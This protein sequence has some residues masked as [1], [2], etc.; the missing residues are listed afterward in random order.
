MNTIKFGDCVAGMWRLEPESVDLAF[1]D[2]PFNIGFDYGGEYDDSLGASE[3]SRWSR[4]WIEAVYRVVKPTGAFWLAIGDEWAADLLCEARSLG[5]HQRSWVIW[6]YTFG[7]NSV[8]KYSRS[9]AHLLYFTKHRREF[10]FNRGAARIPSARELVYNDK[11]ANPDGRLPDDTWIIRPQELDEQAFPEFS[12]TW[13]IPRIAGTFNQR[14]KDIPNQMPEQLLGRIIRHCSN[15][16]E[17]VL[18]PFMGSG[19]T[20]VV[21]KKLGR[22]YVGFE[23]SRRFV[24][25][26]RRRVVECN[27]GDPLDG[28]IPQGAEEDDEQSQNRDA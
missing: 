23:Q 17:L 24:D 3:Y 19:T 21:A 13:H 25:G 18:D 8:G 26:A 5:F 4:D 11:R 7:M 16:G 2:P 28:P 15:E 27:H 14:V 10:T 6:Y 9:H 20:A 1:A 12:D 22:Q